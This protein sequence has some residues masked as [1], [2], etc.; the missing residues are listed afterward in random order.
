L[1]EYRHGGKN[2]GANDVNICCPFCGED[3]FH[4]GI[5]KD[6]GLLNCWVC[7]FMDRDK[8]PWFLDLIVEIDGVSYPRA[9]QILDEFKLGD[10]EDLY[11]D[12][13][14]DRPES[15]ELPE[16]CWDFDGINYPEIRAVADL[17]L[18]NRG[19]GKDII[20]RY[21]L[22]FCVFGDYAYRII[23]PITMRGQ[24]V[25]YLGRDFTDQQGLRYRNCKSYDALL[26]NKEL[27]YGFDLFYIEPKFHAY[28]VE[29]CTDV[30]R[31]GV[32]AMAT[33]S[34]KL[35]P[36]QRN[37]LIELNLTSIT[38]AFDPGSYVRGL[39]AAEQLS[40][41][42]SKIKVLNFQ[43]NRDVAE[44]SIEEIKAIEAD[45]RYSLF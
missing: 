19:F 21:D 32:G 41:F 3:R 14:K 12:D 20:D 36:I 9:K 34:N 15:L 33:L 43:D 42:I 5:H 40:P 10:D 28:L 23:V 18:K 4:L 31:I 39:E 6:K 27:L 24:L 30:W 22:K 11:V 44:H 45:T 16:G 35:Y 37:L 2:V 38:I 26:R 1:V 7:E 29:G 25:S 8:R 13:Y 17:Y